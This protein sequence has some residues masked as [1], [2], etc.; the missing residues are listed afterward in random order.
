MYDKPQKGNQKLLR[1]QLNKSRAV[2]AIQ[3]KYKTNSIFFTHFQY[4]TTLLLQTRMP[5][6]PL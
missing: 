5:P 4:E 3:F 1:T 2:K 6:K